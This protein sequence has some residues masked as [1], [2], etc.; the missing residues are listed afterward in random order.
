MGRTH[1][2]GQWC[3]EKRRVGGYSTSKHWRPSHI[4]ACFKFVLKCC[5]EH[6]TCGQCTSGLIRDKKPDHLFSF[7]LLYPSSSQTQ[8]SLACCWIVWEMILL[9]EI[10]WN[11]ICLCEFCLKESSFAREISPLTWQH[12]AILLVP[13][14]KKSHALTIWISYYEATFFK[15]FVLIFSLFFFSSSV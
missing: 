12:T 4:Q 14:P 9:A 15:K 10:F 8:R 2:S 6:I 7:K 13:L 5:L 1:Y 11:S 3:L